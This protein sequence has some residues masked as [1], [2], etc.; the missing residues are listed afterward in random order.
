GGPTFTQALLFGSSA[1]GNG[2][3]IISNAAPINGLDQR[4]F[5][6]TTSDIGAYSYNFASA[7]DAVVSLDN[8]SQVVLTLSSS[9]TAITDFHTTYN[10]AANTLTITAATTGTLLTAPSAGIAGISIINGSTDTITLDL[11]LLVNFAGLVIVG[12]SGTDSVTIGTGGVD[13]SAVTTGAANL[14]FTANILG[15]SNSTS[16][17]TLSN[18]IKTKGS[19]SSIY[20]SAG[21]INGSGL[22]TTPSIT[23]T[24]LSGIG[25]TNA[26]NLASQAIAA[27]SKA[28]KIVINNSSASDVTVSSLTTTGTTTTIVSNQKRIINFAQVG[29]GA[30]TFSNVSTVG[31]TF[32]EHGEIDLSNDGDLTIGAG[33]VVSETTSNIYIQATNSRNITNSGN[34][35]LNGNVNASVGDGAISVKSA[36]SISGTGALISGF[37]G[38]LD[39]LIAGTG[40][41][42]KTQG[43]FFA[44]AKISTISGNISIENTTSINNLPTISAPANLSIKAGGSITQRPDEPQNNL[45]FAITVAGTASFNAVNGAIDLTSPAN[46]FSGAVSLTNTGTYNVA[47]TDTNAIDFGASALGR[48]TFTVNAVGITQTGAITQAS[49]AG[50]ATFNAGAGVI[51]LTKASNNFTGPVKLNSTGATVAISDTDAIDFG[52]SVLGTGS[53]TVNAVGITQTGAITQ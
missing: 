12:N 32:D 29:G 33:G 36:G 46:N 11:N 7:G 15:T 34:I 17:L 6:R 53:L 9:G 1:I 19:A 25:D 30:V 31:T 38:R 26:I 41:D 27:D 50:A 47:I 40:I 43:L 51:T 5:V 8:S 2:N 48:G 22:I 21:T 10:S 28:G 13:L 42:V 39:D 49:L 44:D 35:I 4:G 20:L 14:S 45:F 23:M 18:D 16:A 37:S 3:S 52:S 24:A